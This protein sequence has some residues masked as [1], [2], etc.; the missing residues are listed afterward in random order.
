[1]GAMLSLNQSDG[2]GA[3]RRLNFTQ[4]KSG[5]Q[6]HT[7]RDRMPDAEI[8]QPQSEPAAPPLPLRQRLI[9]HAVKSWRP[10]GTV[11]A[12]ILALLLTWHVIYGSH[13]LYIWQQKRAEDHA[14]QLEIQ[15]LEHENSDMQRQID[16]LQSDPDAIERE[17]RE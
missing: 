1:M 15:R 8:P 2:S 16:R 11:V 12:V 5:L 14:L 4:T 13:G 6:A 7:T 9:A 17:A 3:F 10:A